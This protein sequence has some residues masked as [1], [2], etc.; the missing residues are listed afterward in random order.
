MRVKAGDSST[1]SSEPPI[2]D[3]DVSDQ[4]V[5]TQDDLDDEAAVH[6][7]EAAL[8]AST[9]RHRRSGVH[10]AA[11]IKFGHPGHNGMN[12]HAAALSPS[13]LGRVGV[14]LP[15]HSRGTSPI[16]CMKTMKI[17]ADSK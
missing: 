6:E 2:Q 5:D 13:A 1:M 10:G 17:V 12:F 16:D 3:V 7:A 9:Q 8:L 4:Y 11:S 14:E 15:K